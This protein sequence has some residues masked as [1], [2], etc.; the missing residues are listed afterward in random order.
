MQML[1]PWFLVGLIAIAIPIIVHLLQLRRPQRVV[2]TNNSF[3]REVE[4]VAVRQRK[5]HQL[6]ILL[7][8]ILLISALVVAFSQ[9]FVSLKGFGNASNIDRIVNVLIDNSLSMQL[10]GVSQSSV[11]L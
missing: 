5:V 1:Y 4:L 2:F 6:L 9:P 8:R 10:Q 3:I 11:L 7:S